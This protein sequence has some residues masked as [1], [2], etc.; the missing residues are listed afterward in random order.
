M[1]RPKP[2]ELRSFLGHSVHFKVQRSQKAYFALSAVLKP[3]DKIHFHGQR[4]PSG[5]TGAIIIVAQTKLATIEWSVPSVCLS[6]CLSV[7]PS[8]SLSPSFLSCKKT[9]VVGT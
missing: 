2:V 8:V 1:E 9:K 6:V 4:P 7:C 3:Y 5:G